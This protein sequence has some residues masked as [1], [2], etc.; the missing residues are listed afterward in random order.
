MTVSD[1]TKQAQGLGIFFKS[2]GKSSVRVGEKL[3]K[4]VLSNPSQALDITAN[5]PTTAASRNPENV[6]STL[7]ELIKFYHTGKRLYFGKFV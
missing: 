5:I 2:L 1:K 6:I 7:L 4:N 3:A